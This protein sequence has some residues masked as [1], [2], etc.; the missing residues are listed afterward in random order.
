MVKLGHL[1]SRMKDFYDIWLLSR[2][3]Q[4]ELSNLAEAVKLTFRQRRTE[5]KHPIEAFSANFGLSRQ[6]MWTAFCKRLKQDHV[7][8]SFQGI[9]A[10]VE[11]FLDPVIK[12][13]SD[14]IVW[15]PAGPWS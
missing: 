15:K 12:G 5:L 8:A 9:T 4:F 14:D 11:S 6:T 13:V 10:A 3:F 1:N 7:P 2:Q